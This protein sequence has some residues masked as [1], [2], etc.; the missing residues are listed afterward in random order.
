MV[1]GI[2][3]EHIFNQEIYIKKYLKILKENQVKTNLKIIAYCIMTNH[4][5]IL[6][7]A[8]NVQELSNLMQKVNGNYARY[9]NYME[10][11]V[12]YVFRDRFKSQPIMSKKQLY[13]CIRYIHLNPVKAKMVDKPEKYKYSSYNEYKKRIENN[14]NL[15]LKILDYICNSK[16]EISEQFLDINQDKKEIINNSLI[17]FLRINRI[18]LYEIL[19]KRE[20]LKKLIKYLK[21]EKEIKYV[22]IM[23]HFEINKGVMQN[24]KK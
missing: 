17:E 23:N 19:E 4:A 15:E 7:K 18:N 10:N 22:D 16:E 13:N 1:Q 5:H 2:N 3:K 9:Y 24:L 8:E 14:N 11:R 6:I 12:G 21:N 20:I